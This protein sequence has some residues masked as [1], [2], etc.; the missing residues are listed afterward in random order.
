[1]TMRR[2]RFDAQRPVD[3]DDAAEEVATAVVDCASAEEVA[4]A[5]AVVETLVDDPEA[6]VEEACVAEAEVEDSE[7][8]VLLV[9]LSDPLLLEEPEK[10][11]AGPG[12]V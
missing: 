8:S 5:A 9:L 7:L 3:E 12:A 6:C 11:T 4:V 2:R 1:M 10:A